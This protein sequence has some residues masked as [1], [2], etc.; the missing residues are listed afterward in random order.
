MNDRIRDAIKN[1]KAD[2]TEIRFEDREATTIAYRGKDLETANAVVD[3]GGIV[4]CLMRNGG[5]GIVTLG[6]V[7]GAVP[8][9]FRQQT[10]S[11]IVRFLL[12]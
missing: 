4:R 8:D 9:L 10:P 11:Q 1:S 6:D 5:W 7:R 2:Y 3:A 12:A